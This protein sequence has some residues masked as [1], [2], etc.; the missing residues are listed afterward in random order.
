MS[1]TANR[2]GQGSFIFELVRE[3]IDGSEDVVGMEVVRRGLGLVA[4]SCYLIESR[5]IIRWPRIHHFHG[6][7]PHI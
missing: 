7:T 6:M 1:W 4:L 5:L 3:T 2:L